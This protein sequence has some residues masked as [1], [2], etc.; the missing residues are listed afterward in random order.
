[1]NLFL[2]YQSLPALLKRTGRLQVNSITGIIEYPLFTWFRMRLRELPVSKK[3]DGLD[4]LIQVVGRTSLLSPLRNAI[5]GR[6]VL[7]PIL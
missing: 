6:A 7:L 3:V 4:R 1:M 5:T 2:N